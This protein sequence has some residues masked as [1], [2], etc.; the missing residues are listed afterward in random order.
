MRNIAMCFMVYLAGIELA[1]AAPTF[2]VEVSQGAMPSGGPAN[3]QIDLSAFN[4]FREATRD[5]AELSLPRADHDVSPAESQ[6]IKI[7]PLQ[8]QFERQTGKHAH[9]ARFEL[10]G[11][12]VF[13]ASVGGSVDGRSAA[14][15][16]TW[17]TSP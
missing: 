13:G 16:L 15:Q 3:H 5:H 11:V 8:T 17:P 4:A 10:N 2:P 14:L 9:F 1:W 6:T 7:G 12:T